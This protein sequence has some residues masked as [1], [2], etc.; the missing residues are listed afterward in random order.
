[1]KC[2]KTTNSQSRTC[3]I[4]TMPEMTRLPVRS[5]GN[6][7]TRKAWPHRKTIQLYVFAFSFLS[8]THYSNAS[9]QKSLFLSSLPQSATEQSIRAQVVQTLPASAA[10]PN[11]PNTASAVRSVVHVA[12]S[13]CAFVNFVDRNAAE[14]AAEVWATGLEIDGERVNVK[15]GKSR[16]KGKEGSGSPAASTSSVPAAAPAIAS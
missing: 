15:W 14:R 6:M 16:S 1:M 7:Q 13:R 12:K 5:S 10:P 4:D 2:P 3:K 9:L 8:F 11:D